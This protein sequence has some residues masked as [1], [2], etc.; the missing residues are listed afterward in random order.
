MRLQCNI[1]NESPTVVL[2]LA[3]DFDGHEINCPECDKILARGYEDYY[4]G[5]ML[6]SPIDTHYNKDWGG[7]P[8]TIIER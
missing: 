4:T 5:N 1:C 2:P 3:P 8:V 7:Y 6:W